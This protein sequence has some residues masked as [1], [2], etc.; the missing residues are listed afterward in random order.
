MCSLSA[1]IFHRCSSSC[2]CFCQSNPSSIHQPLCTLLALPQQPSRLSQ[3]I[4]GP[5]DATTTELQVT[6][7][8]NWLYAL[9]GITLNVSDLG[10]CAG[11][12]LTSFTAAA[13]DSLRHPSSRFIETITAEIAGYSQLLTAFNLAPTRSSTSQTWYCVHSTC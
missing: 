2:M 10:L 6:V 5:T 11:Y 1:D 9:P 13:I 4:Y 3:S 7:I 12:L 8:S